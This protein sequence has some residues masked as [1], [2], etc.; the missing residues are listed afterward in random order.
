MIRL[1]LAALLLP[2]PLLAKDITDDAG[3]TVTIPDDPQRVVSLHDWITTVMAAELGVPL[4]GTSARLRSDGSLYVRS[5]EELFGMTVPEVPLASIHGQTDP[6]Q[7]AALRPDLII[8]NL[9]DTLDQR[10]QLALV[11]PTIIMDPEGGRDPLDLYRAFAGWVNRSELFE[12]KLAAFQA[13]AQ[14]VA[15]GRD[16]SACTYLPV[17]ANDRDGTLTILRHYGGVTMAL[18]TLGLTLA[19][20]AGMV[21]ESQSRTVVSAEMAGAL[22]ADV[23]VL[24]YLSSREETPDTPRNAFDRAAPGFL[25]GFGGHVMAVERERAYPISF[26]GAA[27]VMRALPADIACAE[28][29]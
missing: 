6:E 11:A 14:G 13:D 19:D 8:G 27:E 12:A 24:T 15:G 16:L 10:D 28:P 5:A 25:Q 1:V 29:R 9:G 23:L 7:V 3:F 20:A 4:A 18:D 26:Q 21:P 2:L 17:L 22:R